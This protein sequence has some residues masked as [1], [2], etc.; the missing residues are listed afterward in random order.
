MNSLYDVVDIWRVP[1]NLLSISIADMAP[2]GLRGCEGVVLWLGTIQER[3][4]TITQMVGPV[5][6][7]IE[8]QPL[9]LRIHPDL[10]NQIAM[11]CESIDAVLIG[12]VHSHPGRF[13]DLSGTD[14]KYGVTT[15]YYLSVV[16]PHYAQDPTARWLDC[17]VHV[18][19]PQIGFRRLDTAEMQRRIHVEPALVAPLTHIG[20]SR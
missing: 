4:A 3:V 13:V 10:F 19:E 1:R 16:A 20:A 15:P 18:Y 5:G 7:L 14:I 17:G 12:Q 11:Y 8:K 2:D 6:S 9:Y